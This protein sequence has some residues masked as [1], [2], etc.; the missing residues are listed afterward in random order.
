VQAYFSTPV[1]AWELATGVM[2]ALAGRHLGRVTTRARH[3]L[4]AAGLAAIVWA[5]LVFDETTAFPGWHAL[6]PVLGT[7]AVLASGASGAVGL[8][9]A[10]TAR[11]VGYVGD[12]SYSLYLWHWP[13]FTLAAAQGWDRRWEHTAG[14]LAL[15]ALMSAL[16]FH[17]IENP[18]RRTRWSALRGSRALIL[19]PAALLPLLL[20][21]DWS[22]DHATAAFE[23]RIASTAH[24]SPREIGIAL[25]TN[26]HEANRPRPSPPGA[27]LPPVAQR[28]TRALQAADRRQSIAGPLLNWRFLRDDVWQRHFACYATWGE[29]TTRICPRGD[30]NATRS[31]VL[32][33]D[34]HAGMWIPPLD[35]LTRAAGYRLIPLVK[36]GCAPFDVPQ[37]HWG[38]PFPDCPPFRRW[39]LDRMRVLE[40][41]IIILGYRG[42]LE[43][44]GDGDPTQLWAQGATRTLRE[45]T[46]LS[47]R[48]MVISDVTSHESSPRDCISDPNADL[49]TCTT[50][51]RHQ[52]R[53]GNR[54]T[55]RITRRQGAEYVDVTRLVCQR[56]RC[57]LIVDHVITYRDAAHV[58]VTWT[59]VVQHEL[60]R[61]LH[62][63]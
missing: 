35:R 51:E 32:F 1:R 60:G 33:G 40:P 11:P 6:V 39:A 7:A 63:W 42:L 50:P 30:T 55:R 22:Q 37:Q 34:S 59:L 47:G 25:P 5:A 29:T 61:L 10:L 44:A 45:L 46:S 8:A 17:I 13:V 3:I 41:D 9:R 14:L 19:W 36:V 52:T 62:L 48:V 38:S 23:A 57:P 15:T 4:N 43:V 2:L 31:I 21:V 54:V 24:V 49:A 26:K 18:I 20:I 58:S 53:L 16:S 56:H 27:P 12:L 28:L